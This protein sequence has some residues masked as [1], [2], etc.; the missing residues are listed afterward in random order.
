MID[1]PFNTVEFAEAW[2][3]WLEYKKDE[4]KFQYK[5]K[6]S[7]KSALKKLHRLANGKEETAILI[8][9]ESMAN[10]WKGFFSLKDEQPKKVISLADKMKQDYG[11]Q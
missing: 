6:H 7:L 3:D 5:S 1:L 9:E 4:F 2:T 8:I 10:G 11:I